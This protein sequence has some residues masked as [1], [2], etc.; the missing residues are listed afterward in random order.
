MADSPSDKPFSPTQTTVLRLPKSARLQVDGQW[1]EHQAAPPASASPAAEEDQQAVFQ[2][3]IEGMYDGVVICN[4]KGWVVNTN[5]RACELLKVSEHQVR[6]LRITDVVCGITESVFGRIMEDLLQG[7]R[8]ILEGHCQRRSRSTFPAE[9]TVNRVTLQ[10]DI[11]LCFQLRNITRRAEAEEALRDSERRFRDISESMS[12]WIWESDLQGHYTYC[13][14]MVT[15]IL[16]YEVKE[17]VGLS[18]FH[19]TTLEHKVVGKKHFGDV[20]T[21]GEQFRDLEI[22]LQTKT[23]RWRCI[24]FSGSPIRDSQDQIVGYRGIAAD[25][26][27]PKTK[28]AE[29]QRYRNHLEE[30]VEQRTEELS[31]ANQRLT[32]EVAER[33]RF[34]Q[35]L[36]DAVADLERSN[37]ELQQFAYVVSHDLKEP[38]RMIGGYCQLLQRRYHDKLGDDATDFISYAVDGAEKMQRMIDDLLAYSRLTTKERHSDR[39]DLN[40][41][42]TQAQRNLRLAIEESHA[43]LEVGELPTIRGDRTQLLLLF[44]NVIGNALKFRQP[45]LPPHLIIR[46]PG[47]ASEHH[48]P[49]QTIEVVDNGIGIPPE[50]QDDVFL[51]FHRLHDTGSYQGTGIG[52]AIC[53]KI[54]DNHGGTIELESAV[55]EGTTIRFTLPLYTSQVSQMPEKSGAAYSD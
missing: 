28:D 54:V 11:H 39:C 4:R 44:Q 9:I 5:A 45:D 13:S 6:R 22:W 47:T 20:V 2:A 1:A 17:L 30:L 50:S 37:A 35:D 36:R 10:G 27:E 51:I 48:P 29:L 7:T 49:R 34:E 12:D 53:R 31:V 15:A 21:T 25:I 3:F 42:V 16:G 8:V 40:Q 26:T 41:I 43:I 32:A 19:H 33:R 18:L 38:L 24:S 46:S 14:D 52:L 23:Q 55:N